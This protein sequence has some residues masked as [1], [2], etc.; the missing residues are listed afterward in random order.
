MTKYFS[1]A[2]IIIVNEREVMIMI[3]EICFDMDGTIADLYSV[4]GW[5]DYLIAEDVTPYAQAKVMLNMS[6]LARQLN[7]L[8]RKGYTIKII[9]WLSKNGSDDYN[10]RVTETKKAWLKKHLTSVHFDDIIIVKYG[11]PKQ[12]LGKGI[13][14]DDEIDNR[15][16]WDGIAYDVN[17][18]L[19][20]LKNL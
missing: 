17:N 9:S 10:A 19:E 8:Q 1:D 2:I 11:T 14:F 5:L 3:R 16:A 15:Q 6:A 20:I 7:R 18:I 12:T 13:L 4:N